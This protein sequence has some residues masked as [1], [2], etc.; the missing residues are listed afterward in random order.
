MKISIKVKP[1]AKENK[2]EEMGN[3]QFLVKVK[4]PPKENKANKEVIEILAE[5]FDIPQSQ[6][7]IVAGLRSRQKVVKI[8]EK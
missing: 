5:Y 2:V 6:I 4:A 7:S 8:G 1:N 3:N